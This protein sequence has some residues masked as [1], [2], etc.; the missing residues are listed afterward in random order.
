MHARRLTDWGLAAQVLWEKKEQQLIMQKRR[1][2]YIQQ[3]QQGGLPGP[4]SPHHP[5]A[6]PPPMAIGMGM[7]MHPSAGVGVSHGPMA[8]HM[9]GHHLPGQGQPL[10]S[11]VPQ[12]CVTTTIITTAATIIITQRPDDRRCRRTSPRCRR[13]S[14][15]RWPPR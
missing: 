5:L 4:M 7:P 9:G 15:S 11:H 10:P 3:Q 13:S 14:N 8:H 12:V 1:Q 6:S 2:M